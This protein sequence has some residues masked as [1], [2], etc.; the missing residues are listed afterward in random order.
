MGELRY[1]QIPPLQDEL[2]DVVSDPGE[3]QNL[4]ATKPEEV[5]YLRGLIS[6]QLA[7]HSGPLR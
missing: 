3:T 2:F 6:T 5:R 7:M 4:A 1:P